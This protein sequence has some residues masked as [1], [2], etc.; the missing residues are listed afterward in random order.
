MEMLGAFETGSG[1]FSDTRSTYVDTSGAFSGYLG[2]A[3]VRLPA[4]FVC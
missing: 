3:F 4:V 2:S 1:L